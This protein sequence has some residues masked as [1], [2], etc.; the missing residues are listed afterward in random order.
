[1]ALTLA[2]LTVTLSMQVRVSGRKEKKVK[3]FFLYVD[4]EECLFSL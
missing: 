4:F 1:M 2:L 3:S